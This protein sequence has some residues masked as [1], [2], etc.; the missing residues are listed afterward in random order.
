M[1]IIVT[2]SFNLSL[3]RG[4]NIAVIVSNS[5]IIV[6]LSDFSHSLI[7]PVLSSRRVCIA[8]DY[9]AALEMGVR[10]LETRPGDFQLQYDVGALQV[11]T[12]DSPKLFPMFTH[13]CVL[14]LLCSALCL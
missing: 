8:G 10:L 1:M 12:N 7:S 4:I 13:L 9:V 2:I 11:Q 5:V 14:A 3:Y 6:S